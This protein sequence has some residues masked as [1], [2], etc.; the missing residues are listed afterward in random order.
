MTQVLQAAGIRVMHWNAEALPSA[1]EVRPFREQGVEVEDEVI[2]PAGKRMLPVPEMVEVLGKAMRWRWP[3]RS[4][5]RCRRT[6][7]TTST[8]SPRA[9][10][11][12]APERA[13]RRTPLQAATRGYSAHDAARPL[14]SICVMTSTK[15]RQA[16]VAMNKQGTI[17]RWD[18]ERGFG[19][20][21]RRRR[22]WRQ[23]RRVLP[24][25]RLPRRQ[26][27]AQRR[28]GRALRRSTSAARPRA[29]AVAPLDYVDPRR[30]LPAE[31]PRRRDGSKRPPRRRTWWPRCARSACWC[32]PTSCC[33]WGGLDAAPAGAGG[34]VR[35]AAQRAGLLPYWRDKFAAQRG[36]RRTPEAVLHVAA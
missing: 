3:R 7:S 9:P 22:R 33:W 17:V 23:Y 20:A 13:Q 15:R 21:R 1:A 12:R 11:S 27:R 5:S 4:S 35:A 32:R 16:A 30:P 26:H 28:P 6:T 34:A 25:P 8:P 24:H 31:L 10:P 36:A 18:D 29:M 19:F 2:G 14:A